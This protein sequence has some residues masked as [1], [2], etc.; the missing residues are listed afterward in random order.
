VYVDGYVKPDGRRLWLYGRSP[1]TPLDPG[2]IPSPSAAP[3]RVTSHMRLHPLT[4]E[5]VVYAGHRQDRTF[6]P[7]AEENPL[8]PTVDPARPTEL[9]LGD[10]D[11]AVFENRFPTLA[12]HTEP[13]PVVA[14]V[15]TRQAR[16]ACEVVVFSQDPLANLGTLAEDHVALILEVLAARTDAM[17]AAG[18][19]YVLPFENRGREMGVTLHH[20]HAQ[21][22]G[23]GFLPQQQARALQNLRTY[24]AAHGSDLVTDLARREQA[25]ERRLI[26]ARA[27]AVAFAPPFARFP[28]EVW[29]APLR[30][31]SFLSELKGE[32]RNAIAAVL[33]ETLQRMDRLW[34]VPMPY[35]MTVNQ[36]PTDGLLYP[37]WSLRIEIWPIRRAANKLKYLAGTELGAGVFAGDVLPEAA[38]ES[39][40]GVV[41]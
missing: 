18:L 28:Y 17:R 21:I 11:V 3:V 35:L 20:P 19:A 30:Q 15:A 12:P 1:L 6:L 32:E 33:R 24:Y 29:I 41:L 22:Y 10:Y 5:W 9:P 23:Y 27:A 38:A 14:D 7:S 36:A 4:Q 16:G 26:A 31:V 34:N 25:H 13:P 37:E 39:L 40:R 8:A 2:T